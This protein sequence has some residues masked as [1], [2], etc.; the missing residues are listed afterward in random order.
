[1]FVER[2]GRA[3]YSRLAEEL[4]RRHRVLAEQSQSPSRLAQAGARDSSTTREQS[5]SRF[6]QRLARQ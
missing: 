5:S 4:P 3:F 6:E 2:L 1:M